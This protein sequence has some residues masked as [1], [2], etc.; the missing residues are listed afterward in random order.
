MTF[1][2]LTR[3]FF[4]LVCADGKFQC[5]NGHCIPAS[6]H[7]DGYSDCDDNEDEQDCTTTT[8]P[9]CDG[10]QCD[11]GFCIPS[12]QECNNYDHCGDNSD[13]HDGCDSGR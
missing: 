6:W 13:E 11:N 8:P 9:A 4:T 5:D 10:F 7:C 3:P 12:W 1:I 2:P